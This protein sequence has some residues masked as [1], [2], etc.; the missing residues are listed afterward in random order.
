MTDMQEMLT[1]RLTDYLETRDEEARVQDDSE[2]SDLG[3]SE[4]LYSVIG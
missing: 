4:V 3:N 1:T 2:S